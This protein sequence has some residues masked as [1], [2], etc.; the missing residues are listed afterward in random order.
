MRLLCVHF[1]PL[2]MEVDLLA[3]FLY[4][5]GELNPSLPKRQTKCLEQQKNIHSDFG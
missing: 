1:I 3:E 2:V 5:F 4:F